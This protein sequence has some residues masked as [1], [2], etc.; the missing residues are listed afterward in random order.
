MTRYHIH[1]EGSV[2]VFVAVT[3]A[4]IF[5]YLSWVLISTFW[6]GVLIT[7]AVVLIAAWVIYFFRV[8]QIDVRAEA[9]ELLSAAD[10]KVVAIEQV[11]NDAFPEGVAWQICVFMSPFDTH[12]NRFPMP[13]R[14]TEVEYQK[15]KFLP[16]YNPKSSELNE[17]NTVKM[18]TDCGNI[19][20]M[21]QIAGIMA[22]RIVNYAK[23]DTAVYA[24]E[25]LGFIKFGSRVD[26]FLPKHAHVQAEIGQRVKAGKSVLAIIPRD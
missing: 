3:L 17:R 10:G 20:W 18:I 9:G 22:R 4:A 1:K 8:P 19:L 2:H 14:V 21:R 15:G 25:P 6:L 23:K 13:G 16:A 24:G 26:H 11:K 5:I 7:A 12:M